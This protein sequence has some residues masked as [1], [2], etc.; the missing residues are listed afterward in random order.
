MSLVCESINI[1]NVNHGKQIRVYQE[2]LT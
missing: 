1:K 2:M